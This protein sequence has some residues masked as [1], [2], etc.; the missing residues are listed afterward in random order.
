ML[1]FQRDCWSRLQYVIIAMMP[2]M[3]IASNQK[4]K[5][6][7]GTATLPLLNTNININIL[8]GTDRK[9]QIVTVREVGIV[10]VMLVI[11][12]DLNN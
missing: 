5:L 4:C 2:A 7:L 3:A 11:S 6:G 1:A 10:G 9:L 12:I 8:I